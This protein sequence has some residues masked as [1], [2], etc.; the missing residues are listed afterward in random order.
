MGIRGIKDSRE[1]TVSCWEPGKGEPV[2]I[3]RVSLGIK[4][5]SSSVRRE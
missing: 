1:E 4:K 2:Q 5:G 3:G